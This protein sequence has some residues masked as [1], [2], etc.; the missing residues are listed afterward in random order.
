MQTVIPWSPNMFSQSVIEQLDYYVYFLQ[1]PR[2]AEIFYVGKGV[3]NRVFNHLDCA[4]E[5]DGV[6]EKL[7]KIREIVRAGKKVNHYILRHG[8]DEQTAFEIEASLIDFV[9]MKNLSNLQCGHY[10]NDY[11]IKTAEEIAAIYEAEELSTTESAIMININRLYRREM[12]EPEL[13]DATRKSWVIGPRKEKAKYA[14]ATYRGLTRE[15]YKIDNWFTVEVNGKIRWGFEGKIAGDD[16]RKK[17][18]YKSI[19]SYFSKGAAN[20]IKYLNC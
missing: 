14:I 6:T 15:V 19:A 10:S 7:D 11:G 18:R 17:L 8:L 4:I 2:T 3:G 16:I 13:Y 5:T 12:T 1:D 20:P 9:G